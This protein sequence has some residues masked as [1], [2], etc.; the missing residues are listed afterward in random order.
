[1]YL[2]IPVGSCQDVDEQAG[3]EGHVVPG[4]LPPTLSQHVLT[5]QY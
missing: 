1:M 3:Q 5:N 4:P 2:D